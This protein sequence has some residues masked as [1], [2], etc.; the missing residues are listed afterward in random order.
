MPIAAE[1]RAANLT[2]L[3]F[4][5]NSIS[6]GKIYRELPLTFLERFEGDPVIMPSFEGVPQEVPR[7][8]LRSLATGW[9]CQFAGDRV[10][11]SRVE[12]SVDDPGLNLAE[13][14][15]DA[16]EIFLELNNVLHLLPNRFGVLSTRY[17]R[18]DQ[19]GLYLSRHFCRDNL[20]DGPR[21][22]LNRPENFE[23]H[24]HKVY[25]M[26]DAFGVNSWVRNKSGRLSVNNAE[27]LV[28]EQDINTISDGDNADGDNGNWT[29]IFFGAVAQELDQIL[30]LYYPAS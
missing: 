23:L 25:R 26:A 30:D 4:V 11:L 1:F 13:F 14:F 24:A 19:P 28:V 15:R 17:V 6:G 18:H 5:P 27:I 20:M 12:V 16:C 29:E 2:A 10:V 3:Q 9:T 22:P 7:L 21:A 8:M